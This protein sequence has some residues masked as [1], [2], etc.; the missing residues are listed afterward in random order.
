[1]PHTSQVTF[2]LFADVCGEK[3]RS[4][5]HDFGVPKGGG[6]AEQCG[7]AGGVVTGTW[8]QNARRGFGG[9]GGSACGEHGVE[10]GRE[11][12]DGCLRRGRAGEC[13]EHV[14]DCV[15]VGVVETKR[16]EPIEKPG[17]AGSFTEG[18]SGDAEH[19][20]MPAAKLQL[21]QMQPVESGMDAPVGGE[22]SDTNLGGRVQESQQSVLGSVLRLVDWSYGYSTLRRKRPDAGAVGPETERLRAARTCGIESGSSRWAPA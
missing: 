19:L 10:V 6:N 8:A 11:Q 12:D 2:T 7:K 1:M 18:R 22:L 9:L 15:Q 16:V 14:T 20:Q 4:R 3:N 21:V 17:R 5:R 13:G